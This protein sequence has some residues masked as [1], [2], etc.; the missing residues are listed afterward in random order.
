[1]LSGGDAVSTADFW[2]RSTV[3]FSTEASSGEVFAI[4]TGHRLLL[5]RWVDCRMFQ[6][7]D[8]LTATWRGDT[9]RRRAILSAPDCG[10]H[11][12]LL[13][14]AVMMSG[15]FTGLPS[16]P[17]LRPS[18]QAVMSQVAETTLSSGW[19][20]DCVADEI[21]A[22]RRCFAGTFGTPDYGG[23]KSIPFQVVVYESS[24]G[25]QH[26]PVVEPGFNTWPGQ[27]P[28]VRVDQNP[29][30]TDMG[31][32]RL[33]EELET[34]S[35]AKAEYWVWPEGSRRMA[36]DLTG[37]SEAFQLLMSKVNAGGP[38]NTTAPVR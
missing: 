26:G 3:A 8:P 16:S 18:T 32:R 28:T 19:R 2:L 36:V 12:W 10:E 11:F 27:N 30:I 17:G 33:I 31:S 23:S 4:I 14:L 5:S 15:C 6:A 38:Q 29:P 20:V 37:F 9:M 22:T 24:T 35:A 7:H 1:M 13:A 34:G 25:E 21:R